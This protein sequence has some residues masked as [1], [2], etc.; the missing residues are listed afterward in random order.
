MLKAKGDILNCKYIANVVNK[1][2]PQPGTY[3]GRKPDKLLFY[4]KINN[5]LTYKQLRFI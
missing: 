3:D 5:Q 4:D 1:Y 2:N